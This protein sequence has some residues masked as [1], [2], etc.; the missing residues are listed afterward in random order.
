MDRLREV[1]LANEEVHVVDVDAFDIELF[2]DSMEKGDCVL[3]TGAWSAST[4]FV[5]VPV[6]DAGRCATWRIRWSPSR[7]SGTPW[8]GAWVEGARRAAEAL[9]RR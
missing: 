2:N 4:G 1:L 3:T 9:P 8:R 5:G 7:R 6:L